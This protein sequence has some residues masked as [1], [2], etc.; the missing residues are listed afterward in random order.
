MKLIIMAASVAMAGFCFSANATVPDNAAVYST[1]QSKGSISAGGKD[2]YTKTFAVVVANLSDKD[3]DLAK[4]CLRAIAPDHQEFKLDTVDEKLTKG[5]VKKGQ[6]VKGV[7]VFASDNAAVH[8]AALIRL[9][10]DCE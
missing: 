9:S 3:V 10:D 4:L 5:T 2:T 8:Q 1:E 6:R 7:A